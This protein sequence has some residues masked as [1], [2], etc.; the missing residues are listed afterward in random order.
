M[1]KAI[2]EALNERILA[3]NSHK[4][5]T[6]SINLLMLKM[7]SLVV[8]TS[9]SSICVWCQW[10][11]NNNKKKHVTPNRAMFGSVKLQT[12]RISTVEYILNLMTLFNNAV[13][14]TERDKTQPKWYCDRTTDRASEQT[15]EI[16]V[17][18]FVFCVPP[19]S[20][21][22]LFYLPLMF[23]LVV[24]VLFSRR[25]LSLCHLLSTGF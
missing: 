18:N 25:L 5:F 4:Q 8:A 22:C 12:I 3:L 10:H 7:S 19:L 2:S 14:K 15:K 13:P 23:L 1:K 21:S 9:S 6:M 16:N 17:R 24:L 20:L 11:T